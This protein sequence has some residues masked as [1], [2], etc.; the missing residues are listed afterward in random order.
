MR[1]IVKYQ[2]ESFA[3][4]AIVL[5][6]FGYL[7]SGIDRIA[8][9]TVSALFVFGALI[10]VLSPKRKFTWLSK[11]TEQLLK[12]RVSHLTIFLALIGLV[13]IVWQQ[14]LVIFGIVVLYIAYISFTWFIGIDLGNA[15]VNIYTRFR[16]KE[17]SVKQAARLMGISPNRVR[18]LLNE[19]RL[20]GKKENNKWVVLKLS[21]KKKDPGRGKLY[22][23]RNS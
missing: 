19:D 12:V 2:A 10:L 3:S 5:F 17:W 7:T 23:S 6:A 8:I 11:T 18:K 13:L 15:L 20:V 1:N 16:Y 21:Y 14:Q 4:I 22:E 9:F